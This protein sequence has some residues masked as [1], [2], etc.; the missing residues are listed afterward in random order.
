MRTQA[1]KEVRTSLRSLG[2]VKVE[3]ATDTSCG[4]LFEVSGQKLCPMP[5]GHLGI[6]LLI[7]KLLCQ[8][9]QSHG[10]AFRCRDKSI[11][12]MDGQTWVGPQ[13]ICP[14]WLLS[15]S[16]M[17]ACLDSSRVPKPSPQ[18]NYEKDTPPT[19]LN[20]KSVLGKR[21]PWF[22]AWNPEGV[23]CQ[24]LGAPSMVSASAPRMLDTL[25]FP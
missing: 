8:M 17:P 14:S 15:F 13:G 2:Q 11:G 23:G 3:L 21:L 25:G 1:E 10:E 22:V 5:L 16:F 12:A 7:L 18:E 19:E 24:N 9:P 4:C 6:L 20:G